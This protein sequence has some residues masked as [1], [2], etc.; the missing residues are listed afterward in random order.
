M[1]AYEAIKQSR[2]HV[3]IRV[4]DAVVDVVELYVTLGS[5]PEAI[6]KINARLGEQ[7]PNWLRA[8]AR[9]FMELIV[10]I[11]YDDWQPVDP[12][13]PLELLAGASGDEG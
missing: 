8:H 1:D 4:V 7:A 5:I 10:S 6:D 13:S 9:D 2:I 3:A 11:D 12:K